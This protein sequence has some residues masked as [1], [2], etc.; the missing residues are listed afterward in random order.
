MIPSTPHSL[1]AAI[2]VFALS[3]ISKVSMITLAY[4][5]GEGVATG[6]GGLMLSV[7]INYHLIE[8]RTKSQT[9][10]LILLFP[11]VT[12][13]SFVKQPCRIDSRI[14]LLG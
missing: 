11:S 9:K 1:A 6:A 5:G 14:G 2:N 7:K 10:S 12:I 4:D 13:D 8:F 3:S